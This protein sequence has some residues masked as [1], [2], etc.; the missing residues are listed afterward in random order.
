MVKG[1]MTGSG[2]GDEG[3]LKTT[4]CR[5][6]MDWGAARDPFPLHYKSYAAA[7]ALF[8]LRSIHSHVYPNEATLSN[9][10]HSYKTGRQAGRQAGRR[11]PDHT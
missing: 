11:A 4:N 9:N 7:T 3:G 8:H 5:H 1:L 6:S 10:S 2:L